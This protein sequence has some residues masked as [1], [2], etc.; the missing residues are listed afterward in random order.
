MQQATTEKTAKKRVQSQRRKPSIQ[1]TEVSTVDG[2]GSED[3]SQPVTVVRRRSSSASKTK[4]PT[5][6][7]TFLRLSAELNIFF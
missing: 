3:S 2:A 7:N 4:R 5:L 1:P 6:V